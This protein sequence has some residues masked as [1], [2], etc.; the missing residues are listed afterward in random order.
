MHTDAILAH[1]TDAGPAGSSLISYSRSSHSHILQVVLIHGLSI[2]AIVWKDVAPVLASRG[3]RVLLYGNVTRAPSTLG[4]TVRSDL[5]G[6]GYSD[7]PDVTYDVSLHTSQLALLMQHI[8]WDDAY[9][10]GLSMVRIQLDV[11]N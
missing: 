2:P 3:Y 6:R 5:Y 11:W 8:R 7:A 10:V 1:R 4:L 9:V